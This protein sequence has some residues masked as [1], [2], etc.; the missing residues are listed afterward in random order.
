[1]KIKNSAPIPI[2]SEV[3]LFIPTYRRM[4][5][6]T[7]H[8]FIS[9][10]YLK[11]TYLVIRPEEYN[12]YSPVGIKC[13]LLPRHVNNLSQTRQFILDTAPSRYLVM[14]DDDLSFHR[15]DKKLRQ[16]KTHSCYPLIPFRKTGEDFNAMIH[17]MLVK[18]KKENLAHVAVSAREGNN[19]TTESWGYNER[20]MRFVM[21]DRKILGDYF[22]KDELCGCED[23]EMALQLI[24]T[25]HPSAICYNYAQGQRTSNMKGGLSEYRDIAFH[26]RAMSRLNK[27]YPSV[28][29]LKEKHTKTAWGKG[30]ATRIDATIYWKKALGINKLIDTGKDV[31]ANH[32][33]PF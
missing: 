32:T 12:A 15:R 20:Y 13:L 19:R 9:P 23:F 22:Y 21:F 10:Q 5:L 18:M 28:V 14:M 26:N 3:T 25:G 17:D 8:K 1:M 29:K 27:L 4:G 2:H 24:T 31:K 33:H 6:M 11:H 16:L 30:G 7:T